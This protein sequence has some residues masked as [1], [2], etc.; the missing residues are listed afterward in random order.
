MTPQIYPCFA[1]ALR[2]CKVSSHLIQLQ[3]WAAR[4][5]S[6]PACG[7]GGIGSLLFWPAHRPISDSRNTWWSE[8]STCSTLESN[9]A[10]REGFKPC[11]RSQ[12]VLAWR[13]GSVE[14]RPI[15]RGGPWAAENHASRSNVGAASCRICERRR[16]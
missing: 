4:F 13:M 1:A 16:V 8:A 10:S 12:S 9:R 14:E 5:G 15:Y 7:F 3:G 11:S 2:F 6:C